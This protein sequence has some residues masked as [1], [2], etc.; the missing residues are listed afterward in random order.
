[1][2]HYNNIMQRLGQHFI[3]D[4]S[5][6]GKIVRALDLARG[7]TVIEIGPGHGELTLE[8]REAADGLQI[9]AIEKDAALANA[10]KIDDVRVVN[11]DVLKA[12]EPEAAG[13]KSYKLTGNIPYYVTGHLLRPIG[14]LT[15]NLKGRC[16]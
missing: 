11:A 6:L 2:I 16:L 5:A 1:M 9:I 4:S 3:N 12:L 15:T 8:L 14:E 10:L 7:E 13:R